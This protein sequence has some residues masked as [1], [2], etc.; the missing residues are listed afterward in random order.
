MGSSGTGLWL[1]S[2]CKGT[3]WKSLLILGTPADLPSFLYFVSRTHPAFPALISRSWHDTS[4][5][6]TLL[7][8]LSLL[9][10]T[11]SIPGTLAWNLLNPPSAKPTAHPDLAHFVLKH[12]CVLVLLFP[13]P[14]MTRA[15]ST[16]LFQLLSLHLPRGWL[17]TP[18]FHRFIPW[19]SVGNL[20]L[21]WQAINPMLDWQATQ[22][23]KASVQTARCDQGRAG[24]EDHLMLQLR[25]QKVRG[26]H[27]GSPSL[28]TC[29]WV[30]GDREAADQT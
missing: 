13:Y 2:F 26:P 10:P 5:S 24:L 18:D 9:Q 23:S 4:I 15:F 7:L 12:S 17:S 19:V 11:A 25:T 3:S 22:P 21:D 6:C 8:F 29:V 20:M 28:G 27:T 1:I 14:A 16:A 30:L